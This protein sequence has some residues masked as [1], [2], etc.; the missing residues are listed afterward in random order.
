MIEA[1]RGRLV[2][3]DE[4]SIVVEVGGISL[5]LSVPPSNA[6]L[7]R[8]VG[9][10]IAVPTYLHV[11]DDGMELFGFHDEDERRLFLALRKVA[12]IGPRLAL[13]IVGALPPRTVQAAVTSGDLRTLQRAPGVGKKLAQRL[14]LELKDKLAFAEIDGGDPAVATQPSPRSGNWHDAALALATLGFDAGQ[15][16]RALASVRRDVAETAAVSTIVQAALRW[17][18]S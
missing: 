11:R 6:L 14:I 1:V 9:E 8:S 12:G 17:L 18:R 4:A 3:I 15:I 5:A 7:Q 10:D 2:R 13:S 16:D